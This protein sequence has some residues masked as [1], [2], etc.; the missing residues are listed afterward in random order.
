MKWRPETPGEELFL[1]IR[2]RA[3]PSLPR[4]E[5]V[6]ADLDETLNEIGGAQGFGLYVRGACAVTALRRLLCFWSERVQQTANENMH[7]KIVSKFVH[8][9]LFPGLSESVVTTLSRQVLK[10]RS[11]SN[12]PISPSVR[13]LVLGHSKFFECYLCGAR[14]AIDAPEENPAFMT[15]EH[16]W[17]ASAG[18][19]SVSENLLPACKYCQIAKDDSVSWEWLNAH[20]V[21]LSAAPT[22]DALKSVRR[23]VKIARHYL[24][25]AQLC[26]GRVSLRE[27]FLKA[28]PMNEDLSAPSTTLPVTFFDLRT[29]AIE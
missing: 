10:A 27:G 18:G 8:S 5:G 17:P 2:D 24:R 11:A 21:V 1:T 22:G 20:N 9:D 29:H 13:K 25:V 4:L 26:D 19:D 12:R 16:L 15:L 28:G 7:V 3:L 6:W 23:A 14:L